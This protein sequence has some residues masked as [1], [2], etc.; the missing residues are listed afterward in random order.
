MSCHILCC[1]K[2]IHFTEDKEESIKQALEELIND[3]KLSEQLEKGSI[4]YWN[5]YASP[6]AV[7]NIL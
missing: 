2:N 7:I 5:K 1:I 6:E 3:Q 4:E